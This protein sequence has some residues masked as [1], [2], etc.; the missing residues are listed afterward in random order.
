MKVNV[1]DSDLMRFGN[2]L[3]MPD[4][5]DP[6]DISICWHWAGAKHGQGRG[7]GK[8]RLHV[9]LTDEEGNEATEYKV[10]SAHK[11]SYLLF[12]GPVADGLVIGHKCNRENCVSPHH[13]VAQTQKE[14]MDYCVESGRHPS[15]K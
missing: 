6:E 4:D 2:K 5:F 15:S 12:V 11:A 14:N 1:R 9:I 3:N 10:I 7:Y 8:F 13:L